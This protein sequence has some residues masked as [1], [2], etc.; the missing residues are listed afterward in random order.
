[1]KYIFA[2]AGSQV[3]DYEERAENMFRQMVTMMNE[4]QMKDYYLILA[5]GPKLIHKNW[6][7]TAVRYKVV[8]WAPQRSILS[9]SQTKAALIHGGLATLKECIYNDV[10]FVMLPL[11]KDQLDN[12]LRVRERNLGEIAYPDN[13]RSPQLLQSVNRALTDKWMNQQRSKMSV[14]FKNAENATPPI[15]LQVLLDILDPPPAPAP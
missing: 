8:N 11:G 10:P 5:V 6:G 3:Q 14:I 1:M 15:G 12:S 7:G 4:P 9:N 13:I 2:T